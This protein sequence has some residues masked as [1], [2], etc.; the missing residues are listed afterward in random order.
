M[1]IVVRD[2]VRV[3]VWLDIKKKKINGSQSKFSQRQ[4]D[5][6]TCVCLYMWPW[7]AFV[8]QSLSSW[9]RFSSY[10]K[11]NHPKG[12]FYFETEADSLSLSSIWLV[13]L[14]KTVTTSTKNRSAYPLCSPWVSHGDAPH[15]EHRQEWPC[16]QHAAGVS[17]LRTRPAVEGHRLVCF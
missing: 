12:F 15:S 6:R 2:R 11:Q 7:S 5:K 16:H 1:H 13:L 9:W 14:F 4:R 17:E 10:I 3:R 8:L